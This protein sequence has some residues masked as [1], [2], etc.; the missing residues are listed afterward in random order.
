MLRIKALSQFRSKQYLLQGPTFLRCPST[1]R[2]STQRQ[3]ASPARRGM[4]PSLPLPGRPTLEQEAGRESLST[5]RTANQ[6]QPPQST[7]AL[8][9]N[10]LGATTASLSATR[11]LWPNQSERLLKYRR[12][13]PEQVMPWRMAH[14]CGGRPSHRRRKHPSPAGRGKAVA[15]N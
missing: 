11:Q 13:S 6:N 3:G 5:R 10:R 15:S 12:K 9:P 4:R 14:L 2:R 7:E 8:A 1:K